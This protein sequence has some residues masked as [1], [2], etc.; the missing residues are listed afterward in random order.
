VLTKNHLGRARTTIG[1]LE[2]YFQSQSQEQLTGIAAVSMDMSTA[3]ISAV[4]KI[5]ADGR[6]KIIFD[7]YHIMKHVVKAVDEVR[8]HEHRTLL[9]ADDS[10][11]NGTK[12]IWLYSRENF[13]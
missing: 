4:D 10:L 6:G 2:T 5:W 11:L 13:P 8:K 7:R 9:K 1:S 12:Y 3:Y